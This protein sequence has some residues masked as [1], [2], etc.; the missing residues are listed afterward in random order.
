MG[1]FG[2][3]AKVERE[4][5]LCARASKAGARGRLFEEKWGVVYCILYYCYCFFFNCPPQ[6]DRPPL[7]C[8]LAFFGTLYGR[9]VSSRLR[10]LESSV[11]A[12]SFR[13]NCAKFFDIMPSDTQTATRC[14]HCVSRRKK[15][16]ANVKDIDERIFS[17][18]VSRRPNSR[19]K[20]DIWRGG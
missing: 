16:R 2:R 8:P 12:T 15:M 9:V 5:N 19:A 6:S 10:M 7:S 11:S 14:L 20:N 18:F 1:S 3:S 17:N 4:K 13:F